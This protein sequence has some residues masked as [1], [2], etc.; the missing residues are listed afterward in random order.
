MQSQCKAC[1][2]R[3]PVR[4]A[5]Q[6]KW[7]VA[8]FRLGDAGATVQRVCD[9]SREVGRGL[10]AEGVLGERVGRWR[11]CVSLTTISGSVLQRRGHGESRAESRGL[12]VGALVN[13]KGDLPV[14]ST[15]DG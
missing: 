12:R 3:H 4:R 11:Q 6:R 14:S 7:S 5:G 8:G 1:S 10:E 15:D 13:T 9:V 2:G